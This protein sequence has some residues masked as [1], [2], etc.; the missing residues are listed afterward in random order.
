MCDRTQAIRRIPRLR[1]RL[2]ILAVLAAL[3]AALL[4]VAPAASAVTSCVSPTGIPAL[5]HMHS[6]NDYEYVNSTPLCKALTYGATSA[7]ADVYYDGPSGQL[8][9]KHGPN[10]PVRGT[11]IDQYL[12]PLWQLYNARPAGQKWLY[13]GWLRP[14]TLVVEI[15]DTAPA[16][17][18][19]IDALQVELASYLPMLTTVSNGQVTEGMVTVLLTGQVNTSSVRTDPV[20][21]TFVNLTDNTFLRDDLLDGLP[22]LSVAPLVNVD[23]CDI[24]YYLMTNADPI[25]PNST[26]AAD[27]K[28][29]KPDPWCDF[30]NMTEGDGWHLL[31]GNT[32]LNSESALENY[33]ATA[34]H[35]AGLKI[36][37]WHV[38][39]ETY[40]GSTVR[41][42]YFATEL[43]NELDYVSANSTT[44]RE[45]PS[46]STRCRTRCT[47]PGTVATAGR[48]S[49]CSA[50]GPRCRSPEAPTAIRWSPARC[51]PP[52]RVGAA[53]W[54]CCS[55]TPITRLYT[56]SG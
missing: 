56:T 18:T 33:L 27:D 29:P 34:A 20:Q 24:E 40:D 8:I 44:T 48:A 51:G 53:T 47:R 45:P 6:H 52:A 32:Q 11:L 22:P 41:P 23:W 5:Q 54:S 38:P 13:P 28:K 15:K 30:A 49:A 19:A 21:D 9:L 31:D 43:G 55:T 14:F 17:D 7:E 12:A 50:P 42:D 16:N 36:R 3:F 39:D 35:E 4:T 2:T 46:T 26:Q 37:F 25:D 10:D 1:A